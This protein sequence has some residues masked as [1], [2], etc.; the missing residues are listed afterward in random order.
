MGTG[1][2]S[3]K[4]DYPRIYN[5]S[6]PQRDIVWVEEETHLLALMGGSNTIRGTVAGLQIKVSGDGKKYILDDLVSGRYEVPVVYF[7]IDEDFIQLY[8]A[9]LRQCQERGFFPP[10][11]GE[12]YVA[13]RK[14]D[15]YAFD[16]VSYY[17][18]LVMA[19]V[20][21]KMTP[22]ELIW[23]AENMK[24]NTLKSAMLSAG[25]ETGGLGVNI[26]A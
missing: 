6:D 26:L 23:R 20:Q 16:E 3:T 13:A 10:E 18:D 24:T 21:G 11:I 2:N 12:D 4:I 19:L 17:W 22:D 15:F 8:E 5:P 9:V 1:L 14:V 7:D 25:L